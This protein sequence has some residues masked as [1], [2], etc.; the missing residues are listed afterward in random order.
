MMAKCFFCLDGAAAAR[1]HEVWY[2]QGAMF[3][4]LGTWDGWSMGQYGLEFLSEG[5]WGGEGVSFGLTSGRIHIC[6]FLPPL[7]QQRVAIL[8]LIGAV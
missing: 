1:E 6:P 2:G 3:S 8:C 7:A 4:L 5:R